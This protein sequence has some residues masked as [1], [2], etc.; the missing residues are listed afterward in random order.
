VL[1]RLKALFSSL[2]VY[3]LGDVATS[4]A[5]LLLLPI[6][7]RVLTLEDYGIIAMLLIIEA[8]AKILFRWGVDTA[9]MRMYYDCADQPARQR[10]ASTIAGFLLCAN[11]LLLAAGIAAAPWLS[12]QF[13]GTAERGTL[14]SLVIVNT[15]VVGF[16][17]IPFQV[18]RINQQPKT[19]IALVFSRSVGT[20]LLR[21]VLVVGARLGVF[22]I[23][24]ADLI[25][26]AVFTVILMRWFAP[27]I[28]PMF[29]TALLKSALA[30]GLPRIPHS[31]SQQVIGISDRYFLKA[32]S[33]LDQVGLYSMGATFGLALKLFLSAF[34]YAWTPFFLGVM[35]QSDAKTIYR[36]I[37]TYIV[38]VLVLLVVGLCSV[39]ED[40]IRIMTQPKFHAA[41]VF[42]PWIALGVMFQGFYL[43]GSIGLIITRRTSRYP[44]ATGLAA[45]T[46]IGANLALIPQF[47]GIGAAWSQVIAY[48]TLAVVT[49]AFSQAEYP[50]PYEWGRLSRIAAAG[51]LAFAAA[52]T[53]PLA[54]HPVVAI[55]VRGSV[56]TGAY[57][58]VLLATGFFHAGEL[59]V[60]RDTWLRVRRAG[61]QPQQP[62]PEAGQVE[63]AGELVGTGPE[64]PVN[65]DSPVPRR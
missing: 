64:P 51:I 20:L 24:L 47:G 43:I 1:S 40:V 36:Q 2:A 52:S 5:N 21:L 65:A 17:F 12:S 18:M 57:S 7:T 11:G 6:Y 33:T 8:V 34:E 29:S 62:E 9:F 42:T 50:I 63:M 31:L 30:F 22:G 39:A 54:S 55:L 14:I 10:L 15:F 53:V 37:S 16:Y 45:V 32:F 27:L 28:R 35:K 59:R 44:I 13:L 60:L 58:A 61:A 3:G 26:T 19:F 25:V 48:A 56:A 49:I 23:V 4:L 38:A 41:A 46:S